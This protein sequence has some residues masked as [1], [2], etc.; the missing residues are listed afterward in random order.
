MDADNAIEMIQEGDGEA[1]LC[2]A[3]GDH[4]QGDCDGAVHK[5]VA[6][7]LITCDSVPC[8]PSMMKKKVEVITA[9]LATML[10]S[11]PLVAHLRLALHLFVGPFA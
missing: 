9:M 3:I 2:F 5:V 7:D 4:L 1:V 8:C 6:D 10:A 11:F